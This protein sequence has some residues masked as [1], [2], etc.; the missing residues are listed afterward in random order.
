M[1]RNLKKLVYAICADYKRRERLLS[2]GRLPQRTAANYRRMNAAID[3]A[4]ARNIEPCDRADMLRSLQDRR[5][6]NSGGV[7]HRGINQFYRTKCRIMEDI[8]ASLNLI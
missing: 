8:A 1:D 2:L 5:G 7:S 3:K 6:Y 4:I